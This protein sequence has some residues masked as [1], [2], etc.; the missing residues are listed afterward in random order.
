MIWVGCCAKSNWVLKQSWSQVKKERVELDWV[1][2]SWIKS[3]R[4]KL[5]QVELC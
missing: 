5:S 1:E 3:S 4:V 2:L